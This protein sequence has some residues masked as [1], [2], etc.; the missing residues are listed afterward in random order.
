M[1]TIAETLRKLRSWIV[2]RH[3]VSMYWDRMLR[4]EFRG[5]FLYLLEAQPWET[6]RDHCVQGNNGNQVQLIGST[7]RGNEVAADLSDH[8]D[9]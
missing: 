3:F 6:I 1:S 9:I 8:R 4:Q 5:R 7:L 2:A